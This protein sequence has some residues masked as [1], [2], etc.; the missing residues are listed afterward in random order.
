MGSF[1]GLR[2]REV[3]ALQLRGAG[4]A[5]ERDWGTCQDPV[6]PEAPKDPKGLRRWRRRRSAM[7]LGE[8]EL[9][10]PLIQGHTEGSGAFDSSVPSVLRVKTA[11]P[12][13]QA[14]NW[15]RSQRLP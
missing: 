8:S 13:T 1:G 11:P 2:R 15:M 7:R 14:A 4:F 6:P 10:L 5:I 9:V 12:R 3:K